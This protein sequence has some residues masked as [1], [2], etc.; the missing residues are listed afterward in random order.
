LK[1][2]K[3][4]AG[5]TLIY[6]LGTMVPRLMNYI[7]LTPYFTYNLFKDAPQ[8]YGKVTELYA[9]IT[10]LM[11]VLTYGMETTYFRFINREK[12]KKKVFSTILSCL[13]C[14]SVIFLIG[15]N[16]V[17]NILAEGLKYKGE[18][19]FIRLLAGILA[20]EAISAIPFAKL[21]VE[22]RAK[23]F[24]ILKFI[25]ICMNIGLM[26]VIYNVLPS[27]SD[28]IDFLYNDDGIVSSQFIFLS[29]M[30]AST[31]IL[32]MLLPEFKYYSIKKFDFKMVKP[33]ML[34]GLPLMISG[35]AGT[36]NETLDRTIYKHVIVDQDIALRELGIYGANYKIGGLILIFIQMFRYAAEPYFFN[37]EKDKDSKDQY[38]SLMHIF[39]GIITSMSLFILLFLLIRDHF[40]IFS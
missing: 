2:I 27:V 24:A 36:I 38:A 6:G 39:V 15:I 5:Q 13:L 33:L 40:M 32:I 30:V 18:E 8:E 3:Q 35:L 21:R 22:N 26:L 12:D 17:I 28:N 25:H 16:S 34:Y 29:N 14:T 4:L 23:R 9:Y 37:K 7:I 19:I 31:L 20:V 10:F 11:I 1:E